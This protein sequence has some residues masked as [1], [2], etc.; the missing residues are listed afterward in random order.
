M[1][2][3][4][5]RIP[6]I[7]HVTPI[8][9]R[10]APFQLPPEYAGA[11]VFNPAIFQNGKT[12]LIARIDKRAGH[13]ELGEFEMD[14]TGLHVVR[15]NGIVVSAAQDPASSQFYSREDPKSFL[16]YDPE[17]GKERLYLVHVGWN[18]GTRTEF[19]RNPVDTRLFLAMAEGPDF[20]PFHYFGQILD[21]ERPAKDGAIIDILRDGTT[22]LATRPM[23]EEIWDTE[24]FRGR[25]VQGPWDKI[26]EIPAGLFPWASTQNGVSE[27]VRL[28]RIDHDDTAYLTMLHGVNRDQGIAHTEYSNGGVIWTPKRGVIAHARAP[29]LE[30]TLADEVNGL[31]RLDPTRFWKVT[32]ANGLTIWGPY[33]R[34]AHGR[35]DINVGITDIPFKPYVHHLLELHSFS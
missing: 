2:T 26:D 6:V 12:R 10:D 11:D 31:N 20:R 22:Y 7:K 4:E 35:G 18:G 14:P 5:D 25:T 3:I 21:D 17:T 28:G 13:G 29:I 16:H 27:W 9:G 15:F 32:F 23:T 34:V 1:P 24:I 30:A 8:L 19:P 33:L